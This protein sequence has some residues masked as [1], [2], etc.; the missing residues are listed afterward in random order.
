[1]TEPVLLSELHDG[2]LLLTW[3]RPERN[4][5]WTYELEEAYFDALRDAS[6]NPEVR[7]IVVTGAGRSFCPGLDMN[8]LSAATDGVDIDRVLT[9]RPHTFARQIPKPTI[10]AVNGA[11]AGI[12]FVQALCCDLRFAAIGAR[13]TTAFARRGLPAEN[14]LAWML[15]R[16]VGTAVATDLL[17]SARVIEA[18]EAQQLGLV[19]RVLPP[20][21]LIPAALA[22]AADLAVNCS[23]LAMATIKQQLRDDWDRDQDTSRVAALKLVNQLSRRDDFR[24]GIRSFVEK[25]APQFAGLSSDPEAAAPQP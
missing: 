2:V 23:P 11:C 22:Y 4:N 24:E 14:S 17:L 1:V 20:D 5:G 13:F 7:A 12:G 18:A 25:R 6:M 9:S 8:T 16:A 3:N 19:N 15:P 21:E 10:A